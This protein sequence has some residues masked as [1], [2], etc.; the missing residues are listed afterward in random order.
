MVGT[1]VVVESDAGALMVAKPQR[2]TKDQ[3]S[4]MVHGKDIPCMCL[5]SK[6]LG[7]AA[8]GLAAKLWRAEAGLDD[9]WRSLS[10]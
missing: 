5:N 1:S 9:L 3:H 4:A 7:Q 6:A 10:I 2:L 8:P